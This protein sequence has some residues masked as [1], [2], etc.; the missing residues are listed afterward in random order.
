MPISC[1]GPSAPGGRPERQLLGLRIEV[2]EGRQARKVAEITESEYVQRL[3]GQA[4]DLRRIIDGAAG[5]PDAEPA[6]D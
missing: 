4:Q 3:R 1:H 2:D 6:G 5:R